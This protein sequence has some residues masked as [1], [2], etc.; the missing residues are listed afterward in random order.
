MISNYFAWEV[1]STGLVDE[2]MIND[3][4]ACATIWWC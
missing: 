3:I 2:S 4:I 1:Y